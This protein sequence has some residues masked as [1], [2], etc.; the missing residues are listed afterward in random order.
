MSVRVGLIK[1]ERELRTI[2]AL[3]KCYVVAAAGDASA[4]LPAIPSATT[5]PNPMIFPF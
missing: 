4:A 1:G 5:L 2:R 3:I